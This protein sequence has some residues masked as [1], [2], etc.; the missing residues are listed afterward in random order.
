MGVVSMA[1]DIKR[2]HVN[3]VVMY[4]VGAFMQ[5]IGKDSYIV[6]YLLGYAIKNTND[7]IPT[8]GFPKNAI[9]KVIVKLERNKID[10]VIIDTRNN[11]EVDSESYNKNL[12]NYYKILEK[13]H[14]Y[15]KIKKRLEKIETSLISKID[16]TETL[17]KIK[18]IES[19]VYD[20]GESRN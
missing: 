11:Y 4:K 20:D 6:S 10:Y 17:E 19:I 13:A 5:V 15:V 16:K 2:V 7:N 1:K 14:N 8:C 9:N 18:K 3:A 12:N